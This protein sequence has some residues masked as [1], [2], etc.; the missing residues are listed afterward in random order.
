MKGVVAF[1]LKNSRNC[2]QAYASHNIALPTFYLLNPASAG[3]FNDEVW[4]LIKQC[5]FQG[6]VQHQWTFAR[7]R[8]LHGDVHVEA[9]ADETFS[10]VHGGQKEEVEKV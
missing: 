1:S 10:E 3:S 6:Q 8:T 4:Y 9:V 2:C 5:P 7:M